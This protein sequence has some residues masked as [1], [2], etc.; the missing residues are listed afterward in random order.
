MNVSLTPEL[1][2][3]V[4]E[5]VASGLYQSASD[6]VCEGLRRLREANAVRGM[7]DAKI[8]AALADVAAGRTYDG[9]EARALLRERRQARPHSES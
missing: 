1:E 8:D 3:F 2:S 6:I 4:K 7:V 9:E 5:Q